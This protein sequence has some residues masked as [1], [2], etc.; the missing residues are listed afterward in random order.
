VFDFDQDYIR[1]QISY[2]VHYYKFTIRSFKIL[3][4]TNIISRPS[5]ERY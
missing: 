2:T 3:S 4:L 1:R 5:E